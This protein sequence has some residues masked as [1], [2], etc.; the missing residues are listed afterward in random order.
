MHNPMF[1]LLHVSIYV[2]QLCN[3]QVSAGA[4]ATSISAADRLAKP[5]EAE[6]KVLG[7]LFPSSKS[8][9]K[10]PSTS[11]PFD[12]T[13]DC[14]VSTKQK[15]KKAATTEGR[16]KTI[17]VVVVPKLL[18]VVPKGVHRNNL[19]KSGRIK[20]LLF[21][22]SMTCSE[23]QKVIRTGF[24]NITLNKWKYLDSSRNNILSVAECQEVDGEVVVARKGCLYVCE[25]VSTAL[26]NHY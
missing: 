24:S 21:R 4:S 9:T 26:H 11:R 12:P 15:K 17:K 7:R 23:V 25:E 6:K 22:R 10:R 20:P 16:P 18:P 13:A 14:C 3:T 2:M 5:T 8:S 1:L 19:A